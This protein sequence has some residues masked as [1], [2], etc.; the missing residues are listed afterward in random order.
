MK[1]ST[2][3]LKQ[4]MAQKFPK[5]ND[6]RLIGHLSKIFGM[7]S[8]QDWRSLS[9]LQHAIDLQVPSLPV[10]FTDLLIVYETFPVFGELFFP[11]S[12]S[13]LWQLLNS[14]DS[15]MLLTDAFVSGKESLFIC[16][17]IP[18]NDV[19]KKVYEITQKQQKPNIC[20]NTYKGTSVIAY[21]LISI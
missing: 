9:E 12:S 20:V 3:K 4:K 2:S 13:Y 8:A 18:E 14:T 6:T 21:Q 10:S 15:P 1:T 16:Q 5:T 17:S 11:K 7:Q 19:N